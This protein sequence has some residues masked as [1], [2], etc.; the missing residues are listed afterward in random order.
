MYIYF[1]PESDSHL[2]PLHDPPLLAVEDVAPGAHLHLVV[3]HLDPRPGVAPPHLPHKPLQ[4]PPRAASRSDRQMY[5]KA[6]CLNV[7]VSPG[8]VLHD[9]DIASF[10]HGRLLQH[11]L[12]SGGLF[13]RDDHGSADEEMK[14][15]SKSSRDSVF[16]P[17]AAHLGAGHEPG[18]ARHRHTLLHVQGGPDNAG[19]L[20]AWK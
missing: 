20:P 14:T 6:K 12:T 2:L 18:G 8:Q 13:K 15:L 7:F 17:A 11:F 5:R 3:V 4:L 19:D 9:V 16:T 1:T 10:Q